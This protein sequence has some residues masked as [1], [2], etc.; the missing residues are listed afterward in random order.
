MIVAVILVDTQKQN[1]QVITH[2]EYPVQYLSVKFSVS[3]FTTSNSLSKCLVLR[4]ILKP[5]FRENKS[6]INCAMSC[7]LLL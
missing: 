4:D 7:K 3:K 1:N 2:C 6:I 5:I